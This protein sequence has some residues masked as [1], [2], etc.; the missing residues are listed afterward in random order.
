MPADSVSCSMIHIVS[1][2]LVSQETLAAEYYF[3]HLGRNIPVILLSDDSSSQQVQLGSAA[4]RRKSPHAAATQTDIPTDSAQHSAVY[5]GM[6]DEELDSLLTGGSTDDFDIE[7]LQQSSV[8]RDTLK[9]AI[10]QGVQALTSAQYFAQF[11]G[12]VPVVTDLY[13]SVQ[14]SKQAGAREESPGK[15]LKGYRAHWST[16]TVDQGLKSGTV[17]QGTLH[18]SKH[19]SQEA[20]VRMGSQ[21]SSLLGQILVKGRAFLNRAIDG[22]TVAVTLLPQTEWQAIPTDTAQDEDI[23]ES[24]SDEPGS[25][26]AENRD[27]EGAIDTPMPSS[28]G[29][30]SS[31]GVN[32]AADVLEHQLVL[33]DADSK[34]AQRQGDRQQVT[35]NKRQKLMP[36]GEVVSIIHRSSQDM[37]VSITDEDTKALQSRQLTTRSEA[38][39]CVPTDRRLPRVRVRSS[40]LEQLLGKR[41]VVRC[42]GWEQTSMYPSAHVV[43][44]LGRVNDLRAETDAVLVSAGVHWQPFSDLALAELPQV[45]TA[46]DWSLPEHEVTNRRDLRGSEYFTCSI[47]PPGCTDV[48]DALS[49]RQLPNSQIEVGVHIADV[50]YFVKK[51][52]FLNGEAYARGTTVYLQDRRLDM[53]PSLLSEHLCSLRAG[54]DRCAVSVLWTLNA[55]LS[56]GSIWFGRSVIRSRYQLTYQQAQ[57]LLDGKSPMT[58]P[59][60]M[61]VDPRDHAELRSRLQMLDKLTNKLRAARVQNG[62]LELEGGELSFEAGSDGRPKKVEGKTPL[63]MMAVV[64]E[65]MIFA[66]AAVAHRI[67]AAFPGAA[68]LRRHA[69]P[70]PEGFEQVRGL[71]EAAGVTLNVSSNR[72]LA[73]SLEAACSASPQAASLIKSLATRAMSEAEYCSTGDIRPGRGGMS[74][75]GLALEEYTHFTSP[76]RRYADIVVHRQLLHA[77][78]SDADQAM[79]LSLQGSESARAKLVMSHAEL[80]SAAEVMNERHRASKRAQKECSDLY[81]LLLLH[82]EPH[83]EAAV[84]YGV[85]PTSLLVFVPKFHM[86]GTVH[87]TDRAGLVRLPLTAPGQNTDDPF[88]ASDRRQF[89]LET[90][91]NCASIVN[92]ASGQVTFKAE[93]MDKVWVELA[94]SGS[95]AHGPTLRIRLVSAHHPAVQAVSQAVQAASEADYAQRAQRA[96]SVPG[97]QPT[98]E[99]SGDQQGGESLAGRGQTPQGSSVKGKEDSADR[100]LPGAAEQ[101]K[102]G[103]RGR[104]AAAEATTI[105]AVLAFHGDLH[106]NQHMGGLDDCASDTDVSAYAMQCCPAQLANYEACPGVELSAETDKAS[107]LHTL[108]LSQ[109]RAGKLLARAN[110]AVTDSQRMTRLQTRLKQLSV[111]T[112]HL[113][114]QHQVHVNTDCVHKTTFPCELRLLFAR[115]VVLFTEKASSQSPHMK[116]IAIALLRQAE[117]LLN[118]LSSP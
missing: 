45:A 12:H 73:T 24:D 116:S 10:S 42:T 94:A 43:R 113:Q 26:Q 84:V 15:D 65:M 74:H 88:A 90:G 59:R 13:E 52:G 100:Q 81:L 72:A 118:V 105:A 78:Q 37:V 111:E 3:Q 95:T 68:L 17:F 109:L 34:A 1:G 6:G 91:D 47:D 112:M 2:L 60:D 63:P 51:A 98:A 27:H 58:D 16:P 114:R 101:Q 14:Q 8:V 79:Q 7:A 104:K 66:N 40:Q 25:A 54:V 107:L 67:A 46:Q 30:K 106:S 57:D 55:D 83:I 36:V 87:L 23:E 33:S 19:T 93:P 77:V 31:S 48:D 103:R 32:K 61:A 76:I 85:R 4:V 35:S 62:A 86:K 71:C 11:W 49:A 92:V 20:T 5:D 38:V 89:R 102:A 108:W 22:D 64:A 50:S 97:G 9:S 82:S 70:R 99:A 75:F 56:V 39:I 110:A 29:A 80:A 53:L 21:G 117:F 28:P 69:P 41:F 96:E 18:M 115:Q 44:V